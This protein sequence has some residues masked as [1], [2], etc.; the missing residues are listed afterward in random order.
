MARNTHD[1]EKIIAR[2][3]SIVWEAGRRLHREGLVARS[4]GNLSLRVNEDLF[5]ITPS[6]I[7]YEQMRPEQIV[8][9]SLGDL[10][11]TGGP[12][13]SSEKGM[14]AAI[15]CDR[16]E[17]GAVIH[18]HQPAASSVAAAR[19]D[20]RE[21]P[22]KARKILG[23]V[24]RTGAYALPGT[25]KLAKATV[26]ALQGS[27]AALLANHGAVCAG[28]DMAEAFEVCTELEALCQAF[29]ES[30]VMELSGRDRYTPAMV[31]QVYRERQLCLDDNREDGPMVHS[32]PDAPVAFQSDVTVTAGIDILNRA[33]IL[34]PEKM[35]FSMRR[36]KCVL[37][38]DDRKGERT[39]P[40]SGLPES[41]AEKLPLWQRLHCCIYQQRT[42]VKVVIT[43][44]LPYTLTAAFAGRKILP[45]LDDFAQLVGVTAK[46]VQ[47]KI[48]DPR[49]PSKVLKGLKRRN[50]VLIPQWGGLC[51]AAAFDDALAVVQ[52]LEKGCRAQ[53]DSS[54]L[55]GGFRINPLEAWLMRMVYKH[56]YS[57]MKSY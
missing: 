21:I 28:R 31:H 5:V 13:P 38:P 34:P 52:V 8:P 45:M 10:R 43:S 3:Q 47:G 11:H 48:A 24:V 16:P 12:K 25:R 29:I 50:A 40:L 54:F 56:K 9:V 14:H 23:A 42:D 17:I 26:R 27:K 22:A 41:D 4:W 39:V 46:V 2:A 19:S 15:Y 49:F 55:G 32:V 44:Q 51:A 20:I 30:A 7:T 36:E 35:G 6:G 18:T 37:F 33:Q 1:Q 53:I 57:K